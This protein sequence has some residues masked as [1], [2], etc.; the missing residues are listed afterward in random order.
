MGY[1]LTCRAT[2]EVEIIHAVG[3]KPATRDVETEPEDVRQSMACCQRVSAPARAAA[4]KEL[5]RREVGPPTGRD[6]GKAVDRGRERG[7]DM[8][9]GAAALPK[10]AP[11]EP[12]GW[13]GAS[14]CSGTRVPAIDA[15]VRK[16]RTRDPSAVLADQGRRGDGPYFAQRPHQN[17]WNDGHD[18]G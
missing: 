15:D 13:L 10:K 6:Y 16:S 12:G 3:R 7:S 9:A 5:D 1:G 4:G 11:N 18:G 14:T 2:V 8:R 17:C